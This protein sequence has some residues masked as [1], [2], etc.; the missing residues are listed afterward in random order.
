MTEVQGES[1]FVARRKGSW[2]GCSR[3]FHLVCK[4]VYRAIKVTNAMHVVDVSCERNAEWLPHILQKLRGEFRMIH[5]TC[6]V[7]TQVNDATLKDAFRNVR[8]LKVL[9][10]NPLTDPLPKDTDMLIAYRFLED[11]TLIDAMKF[12]KNVQASKSVYT[13]ATETYPTARNI[14]VK[15]KHGKWTLQI[16]TM[17]APFSFPQPVYEYENADENPESSRM[18]IS[19]FKVDQLF[20]QKSTPSMGELVDPRRRYI[21]E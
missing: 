14:L 4:G 2:I 6:L 15:H 19:V 21:R 13:L 20:T 18:Q 1:I 5:L 3:L 10:L 17:L 9:R 12:F 11:G 7:R 16:N 8:K